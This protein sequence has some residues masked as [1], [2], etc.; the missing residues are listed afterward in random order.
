MGEAAARSRWQQH[1]PKTVRG[2]AGRRGGAQRAA[3]SVLGLGDHLDA[4]RRRGDADRD[5]DLLQVINKSGFRCP[6]PRA[7]STVSAVEHPIPNPLMIIPFGALLLLVAL[8]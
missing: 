2:T 3:N 7:F 4:G 6:P 8:G 1:S 5:F